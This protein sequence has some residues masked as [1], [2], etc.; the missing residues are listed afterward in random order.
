MSLNK[1]KLPIDLL[2]ILEPYIS[3]N[4]VVFK[5]DNNSNSLIKFIDID[6]NS[7]F[8]FELTKL[9]E[10]IIDLNIKPASSTNAN[11]LNS[12]VHRK[13]FETYFNNWVSLLEQYANI[14]SFFDDSILKSYQE[15]YF[16]EFEILDENKNKPLENNKILLLDEYL[17]NLK[18]G[19]EFHKTE[20]NK[21]KIE[22]IQQSIILL[23]DNL[24]NNTRQEIVE[25]IAKIFAK[26]KKLGT[27]YLKE[28]ITEGSK[29]LI[30]SSIKYLIENT[31]TLIS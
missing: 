25:K 21:N 13:T 5:I 9:E 17:E 8:Y 26:V 23:Q 20:D 7:D 22:E 14:N 3:K 11:E 24:T 28:F 30:S 10:S 1:K 29:Q 2:K 12:K 18:K 19:L 15:E 16:S 6:E 27:K 4:N 31:H